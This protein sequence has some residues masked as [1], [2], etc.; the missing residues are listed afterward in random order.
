MHRIKPSG[1]RPGMLLALLSFASLVPAA[2]AFAAGAPK[3]L[4]RAVHGRSAQPA[5]KA[6]VL[7]VADYL[8]TVGNLNRSV[9]FYRDVVGL[10][11]QRTPER[12]VANPPEQSLSNTPAARF[13]SA[14]FANPTSGPALV[15]EEFSG[16]PRRSLRPRA[17]DP[18][19]A[20]VEVSVRDLAPV[21][22]A[23][24]RVGSPIVTRGGRAVAADRAG[25]QQ[26]VLRDPDGFYVQLSQLPG[27]A[28]AGSGVGNVLSVRM[29]Y[30]VA[31]PAAIVRFYHTVLGM[32]VRAGSFIRDASVNELFDTARAQRALIEAVPLGSGAANVIS[33]TSRDGGSTATDAAAANSALEFAV[34]RGIPRHTY[35]G[36]PQDVGTPAVALR[37]NDLPSVLRA[38]R[39][40]GT[41]IVSAGG[42]SL[43]TGHGGATILVRD[44][45]GLLVQLIQ[46]TA[47]PRQ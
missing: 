16:I 45:A 21:L 5:P 34:F 29:L 3:L 9:A 38:I 37:V 43:L 42:Q 6:E 27:T 28:A 39:A 8:L 10:S 4:G 40:S 46:E 41:I 26:I 12:A 32:Q 14:A 20:T 22:A 30:T 2:A 13:S 31:A 35:S 15:L 17:A 24:A 1:V 36:R 7:G 25:P 33:S 19:A 11:L 18:G 44:P 23:A 47:A